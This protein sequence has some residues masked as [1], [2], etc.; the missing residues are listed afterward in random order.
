MI[1][2]KVFKLSTKNVLLVTWVFSV[3]AYF[4]IK[5]E[6]FE[7][8]CFTDDLLLFSPPAVIFKWDWPKGKQMYKKNIYKKIII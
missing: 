5:Y 6:V 3:S 7:S 2:M 8:F 4:H 1:S